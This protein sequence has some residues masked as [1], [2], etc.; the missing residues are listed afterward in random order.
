M[1]TKDK[2][3]LL[4]NAIQTL[5]QLYQIFDEEMP[6]LCTPYSELKKII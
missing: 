3:Q 4:N 6:K 1:N 5:M 2:M